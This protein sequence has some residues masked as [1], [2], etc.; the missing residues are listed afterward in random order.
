[1]KKRITKKLLLNKETVRAL[2]SHELRW[3]AGGERELVPGRRC[4]YSISWCPTDGQ[5]LTTNKVAYCM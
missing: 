1:M 3:V 4:A 5:V 2:Q